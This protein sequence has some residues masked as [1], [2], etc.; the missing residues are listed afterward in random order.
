MVTI[1][2]DVCEVSRPTYQ[3][4]VTPCWM[5]ELNGLFGDC[6]LGVQNEDYHEYQTCEECLRRIAEEMKAEQEKKKAS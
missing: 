1:I 4:I 6:N 5:A 2:C 3:V